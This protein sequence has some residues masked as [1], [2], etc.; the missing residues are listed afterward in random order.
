MVDR[1]GIP[2]P[3]A[4][5]RRNAVEGL[6]TPGGIPRRMYRIC[7]RYQEIEGARC[8]AAEFDQARAH[9]FQQSV[10]SYQGS[11]MR[12]KEYTSMP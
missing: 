8:N 6:Q 3:V 11:L 5:E 12:R 9:G 1:R 7:G 4:P 2:R 10:Y